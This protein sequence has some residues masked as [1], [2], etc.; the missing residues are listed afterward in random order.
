MERS[1]DV[2]GSP[3]VAAL[4]DPARAERPEA[5][6]SWCPPILIA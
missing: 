6:S 4:L 1:F 3:G 5:A 2:A